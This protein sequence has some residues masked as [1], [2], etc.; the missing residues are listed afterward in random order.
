M[1][2]EQGMSLALLEAEKAYKENEVPV[3]AIVTLNDEVIGRGHNRREANL[4]ISSHAEIEALKDAAKRLGTWNLKD[5]TLYVTVEPC[6]MCSGA[7]LQANVSR[8]VY[9]TDDPSM[10][11]VCSHLG[12]FDDPSFPHRPLL[13]KGILEKEC[14]EKMESFFLK[15][16]GQK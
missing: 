15:L 12:A 9:G 11:A 14:K 5:C 4:D 16:R 3:G 1:T 7:I 13:T 8:V 6:M 2:D 10:G